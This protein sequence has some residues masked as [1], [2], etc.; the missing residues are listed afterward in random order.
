VR[1]VEDSRSQAAGSSCAP[2]ARCRGQGLKAMDLDPAVEE[3]ER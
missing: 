2:R 1:E 3:E